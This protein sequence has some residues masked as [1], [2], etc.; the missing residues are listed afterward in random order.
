MKKIAI[1]NPETAVHGEIARKV[2]QEKGLWDL[3]VSKLV[4]APDI[5]QVFQWASLGAVDAAF[6][7]N[8]HTYTEQGKKGCYYEMK[9]TPD[10]VYSACVIKKAKRYELAKQF[11]MF[12]NSPDAEKIKKNMVINK[13]IAKTDLLTK[14]KV[15]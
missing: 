3:V 14:G 5:A 4:Y 6:C 10:V 15:K 12:L 1:S 11:A 8:T 9:D 7:S 2:L 13:H